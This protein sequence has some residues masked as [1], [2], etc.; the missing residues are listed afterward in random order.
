MLST[1][2][3]WYGI[4]L[5]IFPPKKRNQRLVWLMHVPATH[6]PKHKADGTL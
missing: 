5:F 1:N 4:I 2:V 6:T 3:Y